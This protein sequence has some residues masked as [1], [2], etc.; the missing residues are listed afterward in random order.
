MPKISKRVVDASPSTNQDYFVWDE[1]LPGFGLRI[2]PSGRKSY[3]LQYRA[4]GRSRRF[5]IGTHG[6][7]TAET[8]RK[9]A[10]IL[11]GQIAQGADPAEQRRLDHEAMTVEELC[12]RYLDEA[13]KGLI[14]GKGRRPKKASTLYIDEGRMKRHIVPLLGKRKVKDV[15]SADVT[16][17]VREV[18]SGKSATDV[19]TK[20]HGRAIVRGGAG[21]ATRTLGVLGSIFTYARENGWVERNPAHGIRKAADQK[22]DRRLSEDEYRL[23]GSLL[24]EAQ[25]NPQYAI[26]ADMARAIALTGCRRSE[27]INLSWSEV[28][29]AASCLRLL[30]SKEGRSIRPVGLPVL[31][32]LVSRRPDQPSGYVFPGTVSG[33]PLIGFPKHWNKLVEGTPLTD[34]T[35]HV[36][37]HSFASVANDLGFTESTVAALL[38]HS[39]GSIT[40]RYIHSVDTALVMAADTVA[41]YLQGL[42]DGV[43]LRRMT[44]ALDRA[45]RRAALSQLLEEADVENVS[46]HP[47]IAA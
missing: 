15:T 37:R 5:T 8:A 2:L 4:K 11:L 24:R 6:V 38:G 35:P 18:A 9:E 28:D 26:A 39:R 33:K 46:G 43:Q 40:S 25:Q 27:I 44:Y 23:L 1:E 45:S 41:G 7:W 10:R 13:K 16:R 30:D 14:L 19:R 22:R 47:S 20:K 12:R 36:L 31:D 32:L 17:F 3:L 29:D 34:V 21:T 42:L